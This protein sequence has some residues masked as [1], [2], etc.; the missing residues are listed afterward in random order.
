MGGSIDFMQPVALMEMKDQSN[1]PQDARTVMKDGKDYHLICTR[2]HCAMVCDCVGN[3]MPSDDSKGEIRYY[4]STV[5]EKAT[6]SQ[7][8]V[9]ENHIR[10]RQ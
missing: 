9:L 3:W 8:T 1:L 10:D 5:L 6:S 2:E 4:E 7:D